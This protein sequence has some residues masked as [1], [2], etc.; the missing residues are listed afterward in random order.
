MDGKEGVTSKTATNQN[1]HDQ[2]SH[3]RIRPQTKTATS[4]TKTATF[5]SASKKSFGHQIFAITAKIF[6]S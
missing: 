6:T 1:G 3:K 4:D 5:L 2:N